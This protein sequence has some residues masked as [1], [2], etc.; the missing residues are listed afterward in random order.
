MNK[1]HTLQPSTSAPRNFLTDTSNANPAFL[2]EEQNPQSNYLHATLKQIDSLANEDVEMQAPLSEFSTYLVVDTNILLHQFE[3]LAQFVDDVEKLSLPVIVIVPGAVVHELDGQKN[4]NGLAWFA[5]RAT[6]WLLEKIRERRSVKG[7]AQEATCK[8]TGNW[9]IRDSGEIS[10]G[11]MFNDSLILDCCMY[12][13]RE[14]Q[15]FLCSADNNLCIISQMQGI[16]AITPSR[17]WSS[18][19]IAYAI[20]GAN[21][22]VSRFGIHK[23]SYRNVRDPPEAAAVREDDSMMV[24]DEGAGNDFVSE[25]PINMLH[26]AVADHFTRLLIELVGKVGGEEVRQRSSPEEEALMSRHAP[27]RRHY[28]EWGVSECLEYLNGRRKVK[29]ANPRPGVFLLKSYTRS[30][31]GSRPGREWSRQGW[32][33]ALNSLKETAV[34]WGDVSIPESLHFLEPHIDAVFSLPLPTM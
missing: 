4:R 26:A 24:D 27:R 28:T 20:Y 13:L 14:R 19:E 33:V 18:R 17:F 12:F 22:D 9:K 31:P 1:Y 2:L 30:V 8:S 32:R 21:V 29:V 34:A 11:E 7:Q 15:T 23:E 16:S 10:T 5:R 6:A 3:V 25:H